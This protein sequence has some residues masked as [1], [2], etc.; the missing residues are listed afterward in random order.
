MG[1]LEVR[2]SLRL[3]TWEASLERAREGLPEMPPVGIGLWS[4]CRLNLKN[5]VIIIWRTRRRG[6][7]TGWV[8]GGCRFLGELQDCNKE[9]TSSQRLLTLYAPRP[10]AH[11]GNPS[12]GITIEAA[13]QCERTSVDCT[14]IIVTMMKVK[15]P[16]GHPTIRNFNIVSAFSQQNKRFPPIRP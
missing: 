5:G 14:Q 7:G 13:G 1:V 6:K 16:G 15:S 12:P 9:S 10:K 11:R 3:L 8:G 2:F 4:S